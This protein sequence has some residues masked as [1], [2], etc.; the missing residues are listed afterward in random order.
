MRPSPSP[1]V[2]G[3]HS[4]SPLAH[5]VGTGIGP[6]TAQRLVDAR[7]RDAGTRWQ[8]GSHS[9][10]CSRVAT[11][12]SSIGK[13]PEGGVAATP[14]RTGCPVQG[15]MRRGSRSTERS[16]A[17][18]AAAGAVAGAVKSPQGAHRLER[19]M[20]PGSTAT[21]GKVR[22]APSAL[23][24]AAAQAAQ[25]CAPRG[26]RRRERGCAAMSVAVAGSRE[27]PLRSRRRSDGGRLRARSSPPTGC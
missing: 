20:R 11:W 2:R 9:V 19:T 10:A 22:A 8:R 7:P 18:S 12:P 4:Y 13:A 23:S 25:C 24:V 17:R 27:A 16:V 6:M 1:F 14:D 3:A 5:P 21:I 15:T 26:G